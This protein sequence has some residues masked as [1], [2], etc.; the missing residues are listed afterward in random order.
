VDGDGNGWVECAAGHRHW[1]IHGAAGLLVYAVDDDA[2]A[3]I[4]MQHRAAWTNEGDT[5][6]VPGGARD[7][8]EDAPA[9]ALREANEEA[10]VDPGDVRVREVSRDDH[11]G[12]AYETVL[13][14]TP[15][16]LATVANQESERLAWIPLAEVESMRLHSGFA[17]TWPR[18]RAVPATLVVDGANVVGSRPNGWWRDRAGAAQG[19]LARLDTLRGRLLRDPA[20]DL[21]V[22]TGVVLVLDGRAREITTGANGWVRV[23]PA[24]ASGDDMLVLEARELDAS[25]ANPL[26]VT[27]D[28]E[29]RERADVEFAG[30]TWLL[31]LLPAD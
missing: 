16:P 31:N 27:A 19:L 10:G 14:D 18:H 4:L 6:G 2:R 7:S 24:P 20:G 12:W 23:V 22:V 17:G 30:P 11:G 25:G 5:W 8:H 3:R 1:G 21:R 26:L 9:A 29:L 15:A 13:A 28:R